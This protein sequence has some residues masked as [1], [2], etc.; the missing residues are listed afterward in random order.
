[1]SGAR[2]GVDYSGM[3]AAGAYADRANPTPD[4]IMAVVE[5][6]NADL[7]RVMAIIVEDIAGN[8][9]GVAATAEEINSVPGLSG[10][11]AGVDYSAMLAAGAY[12]D[13]ANPTP[14]EIMAV[15]EAVNADLDRVMAI[16]VEDIAGNADG[17]A[18]LLQTI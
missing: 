11:R 14:D 16:I 6:V 10:A 1:M 12:A 7:D 15:V 3:L 8:V 2:A 18:R 13:R 17:V 9:D 5:A 4:E